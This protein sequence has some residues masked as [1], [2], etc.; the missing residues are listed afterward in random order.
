MA[1]NRQRK[2][3]ISE[4]RTENTQRLEVSGSVDETRHVFLIC[5]PQIT[6][7]ADLFETESFLFLKKKKQ[8]KVLNLSFSLLLLYPARPFKY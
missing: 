7:F 8:L 2:R 1:G 3:R 4:P 6:I 5:E